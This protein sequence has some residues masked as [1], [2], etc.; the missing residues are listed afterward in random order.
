M[1]TLEQVE[2][3]FEAQNKLNIHYSGSD[4]KET[5]PNISFVTAVFTELAEYFE[6]A[7][8]TGTTPAGW[9]WWKKNLENDDQNSVI[10]VIDVLHFVLSILIKNK[11]F[12]VTLEECHFQYRK[13]KLFSENTTDSNRSNDFVSLHNSYNGFYNTLTDFDDLEAFSDEEIFELYCMLFYFGLD[14]V[15]I[16]SR[17]TNRSTEQIYDGYFLKNALNFERVNKGYMTGEYQKVDESGQ[18][19]NRKLEV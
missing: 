15:E 7:P 3:L 6:S 1:F 5:I 19:D 8:R 18:E 4:W 11:P 14:M 2:K 16:G 13:Y 12:Y 10:E 17:L 9:K